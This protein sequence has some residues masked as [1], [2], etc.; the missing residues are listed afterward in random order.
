MN[1]MKTL[2]YVFYFS[3]LI[4]SN[5]YYY[6]PDYIHIDSFKCNQFEDHYQKE[7]LYNNGSIQYKTFYSKGIMD[8]LI[9][10][11]PNRNVKSILRFKDGNYNL[12]TKEYYKNGNLKSIVEYD[13]NTEK[14]RSRMQYDSIGNRLFEWM[15]NGNKQVYKSK[16]ESGEKHFELNFKNKKLNGYAKEWRRDGSLISK[17]YYDNGKEIPDKSELL[18]PK[19]GNITKDIVKIM[20]DASSDFRG[21]YGNYLKENKNLGNEVRY[22][23]IKENSQDSTL[24]LLVYTD[25]ACKELIKNMDMALKNIFYLT[26]Q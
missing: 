26:S 6:L 9:S 13:N 7:Y 18:D 1:N 14:Y 19:G 21:I 25:I 2:L 11:Y 8:S 15:E 4:I 22:L 12:D 24:F 10:Y 23:I 5:C 20:Y 3:G 16:Y 17:I